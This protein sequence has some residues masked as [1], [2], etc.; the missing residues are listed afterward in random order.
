MKKSIIFQR[1]IFD[2]LRNVLAEHKYN[3]E[4]W[5][6]VFGFECVI[7]KLKVLVSENLNFGKKNFEKIFKKNIFFRKNFFLTQ[8]LVFYLNDVI[9]CS[10]SYTSRQKHGF[11][12]VELCRKEW[13]MRGGGGGGLKCEEVHI[14]GSILHF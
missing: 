4:Y 14:F 3:Y 2:P 6:L 11:K 13:I 1:I 9:F 12:P 7:T 5:C 8:I 10:I